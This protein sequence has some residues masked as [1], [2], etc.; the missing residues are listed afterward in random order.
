MEF[1]GS[2]DTNFS[3]TVLYFLGCTHLYVIPRNQGTDEISKTRR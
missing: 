1:L 3:G 2:T